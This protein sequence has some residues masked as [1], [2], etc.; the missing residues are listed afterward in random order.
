METEE[1]FVIRYSIPDPYFHPNE[2]ERVFSGFF[3]WVKIFTKQ[4]IFPIGLAFQYAKPACIKAYHQYFQCPMEFGHTE[5]HIAFSKDLFAC[6]NLAYND[7][8]Y[9]ILQARAESVL[10]RLDQD[11]DFLVN[12]R[13]TIAGRL[14]HGNFSADEVAEAFNVSLRTLHRKLKE[15]D[16]TYQQILDEVRKDM[17]IAYLNQQDCCHKTLPYLVGYADSRA[18]QRAFKRWTGYSPRQYH[19]LH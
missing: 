4:N 6:K 8:L 2:I 14:C 5:N 11:P 15:Y 10:T 17:A 18:F 1:A 9:G 16:V 19:Q 7:Y 13:S 12:V 3:N